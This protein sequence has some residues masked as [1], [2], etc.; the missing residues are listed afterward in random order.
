M[1]ISSYRVSG[2]LFADLAAHLELCIRGGVPSPEYAGQL[3]RRLKTEPQSRGFA[4]HD[5]PELYQN[6]PPPSR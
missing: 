4:N 3:L 5:R 6:T 2:E 1:A